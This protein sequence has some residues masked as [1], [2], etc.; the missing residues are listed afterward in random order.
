M[1]KDNALDKNLSIETEILPTNNTVINSKK[2][3]IPY[4]LITVLILTNCITGFFTVRLYYSNKLNIANIEHLQSDIEQ[5]E[6]DISEKDSNISD[7]QSKLDGAN[8][9]SSANYVIAKMKE[10]QEDS[11]PSRDNTSETCIFPNCSNTPS[12]RKPY[13]IQHACMD[14]SCY[15]PKANL[16]TQYCE[17]HKCKNPNCNNKAAAGHYCLLHSR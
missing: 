10:E 8:A 2:S 9:V 4:I 13:C 12:L 16:L 5:K 14:V 7:L 1:N 15:K 6:N 11:K 3:K 17:D